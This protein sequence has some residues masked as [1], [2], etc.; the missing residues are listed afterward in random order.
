MD[1]L[2]GVSIDF[3]ED[4]CTCCGKCLK[5][6]CIAESISLK[7]GK[8]SINKDSCLLC[9]LCVNKCKQNALNLSYIDEAV[10]NVIN[11]MYKLI[12]Y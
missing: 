1:H 3:D 9:G 10:D 2:D 4:K 11:R 5:N 12:K 6:V 7:D 8:I